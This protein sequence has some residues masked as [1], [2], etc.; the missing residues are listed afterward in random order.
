M[1]DLNEQLR[2]YE[3]ALEGA[4]NGPSSS[5]PYIEQ[6]SNKKW[7]NLDTFKTPISR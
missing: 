2:M 5:T 1:K 4:M 7:S 3:V 6:N